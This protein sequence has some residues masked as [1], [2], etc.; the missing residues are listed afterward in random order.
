M[1]G[2]FCCC[3]FFWEVGSGF[4]WMFQ[5]YPGPLQDVEVGI[6]LGVYESSCLFSE[7]FVINFSEYN[8]IV[9]YTIIIN[10]PNKTPDAHLQFWKI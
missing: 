9:S 2:I 8:L 5:D 3:Y 10:P 1:L 6:G 4:A 7:L